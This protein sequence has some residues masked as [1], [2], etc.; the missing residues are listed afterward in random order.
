MKKL[1]INGHKIVIQTPEELAKAKKGQDTILITIEIEE[2]MTYHL[3][4][5]T[6]YDLAKSHLCLADV[7]NLLII[8]SDFLWKKYRKKVKPPSKE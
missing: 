7:I 8:I 4:T 1:E 6:R 2:D 3:E 5:D